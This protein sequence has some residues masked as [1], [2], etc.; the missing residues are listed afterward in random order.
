MHFVIQISTFSKVCII[1]SDSDAEVALD[2]IELPPSS[3]E[4]EE[5]KESFIQSAMRRPASTGSPDSVAR[6]PCGAAV[7]KFQCWSFFPAALLWEVSQP[8]KIAAAFCPSCPSC[9]ACFLPY[10]IF[11][12]RRWR[13]L[14]VGKRTGCE[15]PRPSLSNDSVGVDTYLDSKPK[16]FGLF[17]PNLD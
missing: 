10:F 1:C 4:E 14:G 13:R 9:V 8:S 5:D 6:A 15:A 11:R 3:D 12:P 16:L 7:P 17:G 2:K